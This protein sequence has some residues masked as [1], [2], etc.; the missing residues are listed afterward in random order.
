MRLQGKIE[1]LNDPRGFGFVV[2]NG[3]GKK[4]FV[5]ISALAN[6]SRRPEVGALVTYEVIGDKR[7]PKA[8]NV[9][10]VDQ[11]EIR[12]RRSGRSIVSITSG[13]ACVLIMVVVV[14]NRFLRPAGETGQPMETIFSTQ[15]QLPERSAFQC[16]PKKT[17]CSQVSSC[18]EAQFH[19]SNCGGTRMDGDGDGIPCE[20]QWCG[21]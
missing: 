4:A 3:T 12:E 14:Y 8:L 6:R 19:Q 18:A 10:Y 13:A 15:E 2:Q 16:Q 21:H 11:K 1:S 17:Y 7:G 20:E 9:R 5:H